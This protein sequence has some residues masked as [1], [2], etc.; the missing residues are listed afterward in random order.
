MG[1]MQGKVTISPFGRLAKKWGC[2]PLH[3]PI[4]LASLSF[5]AVWADDMVN[6]SAGVHRACPVCGEKLLSISHVALGR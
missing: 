5:E 3:I 2:I 6:L 1:Q 4:L